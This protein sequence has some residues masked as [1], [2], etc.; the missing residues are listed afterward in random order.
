M[1]EEGFSQQDRFIRQQGLVP[2]EPLRQLTA[3]VIGV[4]AIGR[5]VALQLAEQI[6][7]NAPLA[8]AASKQVMRDS[9]GRSDEEN[10]SAQGALMG[11]VFGS[12]DAIEGAKAFAEKRAPE[13]KGR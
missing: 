11:T 13:W 5:Q 2:H 4:G 8:V 7:A 10:W 3:T 1:R 12:E 6:A 9:I